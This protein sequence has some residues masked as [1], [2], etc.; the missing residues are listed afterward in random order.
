MG[1]YII[2]GTEK[3]NVAYL[4]SVTEERAIRTFKHLDRNQVI[5]AWK[6]ANGKTVPN[7]S[8]KA[9]IETVKA[10]VIPVE[11]EKKEVAK[12]TTTPRKRRTKK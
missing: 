7:R 8:K 6:Q 12:K 9:V 4:K 10:V 11:V 1:S 2:L 5:N 3:Y